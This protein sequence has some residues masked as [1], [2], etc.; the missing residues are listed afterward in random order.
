MNTQLT[1]D[2]EK[3]CEAICQGF[4]RGVEGKG[5]KAV[6]LTFRIENETEYEKN[7]R[8]KE[9]KF[10]F[11]VIYFAPSNYV[12]V[13][14]RDNKDNFFNFYPEKGEWKEIADHDS[15]WRGCWSDIL[16]EYR[17]TLKK[18]EGEKNVSYWANIEDIREITFEDIE[19]LSSD[20]TGK[21]SIIKNKDKNVYTLQVN[22]K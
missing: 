14:W 6:M 12:K 2:I 15:C 5:D 4:Y 20:Y 22:K 17:K 7:K 13:L 18:F 9:S 1:M 3:M 19:R 8:R 16:Q 10:Y 11:S 21:A